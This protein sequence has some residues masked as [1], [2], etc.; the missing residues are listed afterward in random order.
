MRAMDDG[1]LCAELS[2]AH[3]KRQSATFLVVTM[4]RKNAFYYLS[5][6]IIILYCFVDFKRSNRFVLGQ[7]LN[8]LINY[9]YYILLYF[10]YIV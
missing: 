3:A 8:L 2:S 7:T 4:A 10:L 1:P 5:I 6:N 9:Q